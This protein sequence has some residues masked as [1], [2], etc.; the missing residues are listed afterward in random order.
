MHRE[1]IGNFVFISRLTGK[2]ETQKLKKILI[3]GHLV[4]GRTLASDS[5]VKSRPRT[6]KVNVNLCGSRKHGVTGHYDQIGQEGQGVK[7]LLHCV[8]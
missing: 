1:E 3:Y 8:D 4:Y 5:D 7:S 2:C 6:E